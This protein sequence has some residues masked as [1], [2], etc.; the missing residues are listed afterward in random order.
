FRAGLRSIHDNLLSLL[1]SYGLREIPSNGAFDPEYHEVLST[2]EG[3]D[4]EIIEVYQKGYFLGPKVL[5]HSKV[6]VAKKRGD[7]DVQNN[8]D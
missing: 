5:R 8:R 1:K 6:K 3:E 4:G 7:D 2:G